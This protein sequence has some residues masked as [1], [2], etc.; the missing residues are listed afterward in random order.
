MNPHSNKP[1]IKK[2][3]VNNQRYLNT[4]YL[5]VFSQII[6]IFN[7]NDHIMVMLLQN[8]ESFYT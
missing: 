6:V 1:T 4:G 8:K 3:T 5:L 7:F 2:R